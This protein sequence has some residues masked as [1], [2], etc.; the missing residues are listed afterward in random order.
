MA[1]ENQQQEAQRVTTKDPKKVEVG[2]RLAAHNC[3]NREEQKVK[4]EGPSG[5]SKYYSIWVV[6][7]V[8]VIG[9]LGYYRYQAKKGEVKDVSMPRNPTVS[10]Q[11]RP[12]SNKF[13]ID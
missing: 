9:G 11:A 13:E 1:E 12:Q 2:K 6:L 8:G 7:A 5:V 3:K 4:S 10:Q